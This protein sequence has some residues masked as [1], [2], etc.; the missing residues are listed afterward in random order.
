MAVLQN[1][2][3]FDGEIR[4]GNI[5]PVGYRISGRPEHWNNWI[6]NAGKALAKGED[7]VR[8]SDYYD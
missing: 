3:A 5:I 4:V 1:P 8:K 2:G 7:N 6:L